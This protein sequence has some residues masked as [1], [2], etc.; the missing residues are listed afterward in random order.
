MRVSRLLFCVVGRGIQFNPHV[1]VFLEMGINSGWL[2]GFS[3]RVGE[4]SEVGS[5]CKELPVLRAGASFLML[6]CDPPLSFTALF[7]LLPYWIRVGVCDQQV[8]SVVMTHH[9]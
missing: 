4:S 8:M 9:F 5:V 7:S 2:Q 1:Y 3:L 6:L